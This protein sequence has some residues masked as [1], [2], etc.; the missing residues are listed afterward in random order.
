VRRW[1]LA[2]LVFAAIAGTAFALAAMR[3]AE[4]GWISP[5]FA[6]DGRTIVVVRRDIS[7]WVV[8]PG[9]ESFTPPARVRLSSD[10]FSVWRIDTRSGDS[11][12]IAHFTPTPFVGTWFDAYRPRLFGAA[13]ADLQPSDD[14]LSVT[15]GLTRSAVPI[16]ENWNAKGMLTPDSARLESWQ[17]GQAQPSVP[18]PATLHGPVEVVAVPGGAMPCG[19][20]LIDSSSGTV[21]PLVMSVGCER[22]YGRQLRIADVE[23]ASHRKRI[24]REQMVERTYADLVRQHMERGEREV[25]ARLAAIRDMR[26]LGHYPPVPQLTA[27]TLDDAEVTRRGKAGTLSPLYLIAEE[28][29][30]V[31]LF[32]DLER[33]L[34]RPGTPVEKHSGPY[35]VHEGFD[36]SRRLNAFLRGG[37]REFFVERGGRV[38]A[39]TLDVGTP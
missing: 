21:R 11:R 36:T 22:R 15:V 16:A 20:A 25:D 26:R 4:T 30:G 8:G 39:V 1:L 6:D 23:S 19:V 37:G 2:A 32:P 27:R 10:R 38:F 33:A 3:H 5:V 18:G 29:F 7:A 14:S 31:G 24:E 34:D 35:I 9:F 13:S 28:E 12:E 17:K